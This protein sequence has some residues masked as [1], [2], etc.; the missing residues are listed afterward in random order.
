[1][2]V[3]QEQRQRGAELGL[4]MFIKGPPPRRRGRKW[5]G[6]PSTSILTGTRCLYLRVSQERDGPGQATLCN[7]P[8][9]PKELTASRTA[10]LSVCL[11]VHRLYCHQV[12]LP[13]EPWWQVCA[14][15]HPLIPQAHPVVLCIIKSPKVKSLKVLL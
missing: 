10:C 12:L 11:S 13:R 7:R 15:N 4:E 1:M 8:P 2:E 3:P 14:L 9:C 6:E 5:G